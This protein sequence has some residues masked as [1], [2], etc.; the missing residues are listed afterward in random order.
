VSGLIFFEN[1]ADLNSL[2]NRAVGTSRAERGRRPDCNAQQDVE[3]VG[4]V[5]IAMIV[6]SNHDSE[7]VPL[8]IGMKSRCYHMVYETPTIDVN[9]KADAHPS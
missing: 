5:Q 9:A 3:E 1:E 7:E 2:D 4:G 8:A 6:R